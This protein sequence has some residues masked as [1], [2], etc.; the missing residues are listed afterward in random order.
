M[1]AIR[2]IGRWKA[3]AFL[4]IV[5]SCFS[6]CPDDELGKAN[7]TIL[8]T[9]NVTNNS[10]TFVATVTP[11]LVN[12]S[13][14][15]YYATSND[16]SKVAVEGTFDGTMP[17]KVTL[18]VTN[19]KPGTLYKVKVVATNVSGSS[20]SKISEFTT[21]SFPNPVAVIKQAENVTISSAKLTAKIVPGQANV[22]VSFEYQENNSSWQSQIL[23]DKFS[24]LDSIKVTFDLFEL[25]ANTQYNFRVKAG[26]TVS[27][28]SSFMTYAV[29]DFDGNLYHTVTIGTQTWLK[30]NF[31]GT[32]FANGDPI[33]NV[34]NQTAWNNL[35]TP[36]YCYYN[37]DSK[38]AKVYGALYNF[39]AFND[40]RGLIIG[41]HS[42]SLDEW[43]TL[44]NYLGGAEIAGGKMKETG[45]E[46][47]IRPNEGATNSSGFTGLPSG[48]RQ[49]KFSNFGDWTVFWSTTKFMGMNSRASAPELSEIF[50]LLQLNGG[51][52][53]NRGFSV[54]LLKN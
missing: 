2:K 20:T 46:H 43:T 22:S 4:T 14:A 28:I 24:G 40:S 47:W 19:L 34:T 18:D 13:V 41:F 32:H 8:A 38:Y 31:K 12:T 15:F 27:E 7:V 16:W 9:E 26:G 3:I 6:C 54:R 1:K 37:N 17:V 30:E 33:P 23:P 21:A 42:P 45:Y 53:L 51:S 36:G 10:A 29:A 48:V 49:D 52:D 11:N 5:I 35:V 39:Y 25:Q 50:A 44:S